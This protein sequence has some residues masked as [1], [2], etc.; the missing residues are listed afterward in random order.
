MGL[1]GS[2]C[3]TISYTWIY[4]GR[5]LYSIIV[6]VL[7]ILSYSVLFAQEPKQALYRLILRQLNTTFRGRVVLCSNVRIGVCLD[8]IVRLV[9]VF[10][11]WGWR[12]IFKIYSIQGNTG[13]CWIHVPAFKVD[14]NDH[15]NEVTWI[16]VITLFN[17]WMNINSGEPVK[18]II[19]SAIEDQF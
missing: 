7:C 10:E 14:S 5:V 9:G 2:G 16:L 13:M 18:S 19:G 8:Y 15:F 1:P 12:V 11:W 3:I 4:T 17:S 6:V